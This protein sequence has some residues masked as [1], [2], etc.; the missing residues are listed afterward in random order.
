MPESK[1]PYKVNGAV[2][3]AMAEYIRLEMEL[4]RFE[5][6]AAVRR[7]E[8]FK[9][10]EAGRGRGEVEH[11]SSINVDGQEYVFVYPH[12]PHPTLHYESAVRVEEGGEGE[13]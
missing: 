13:K 1:A 12:G 8:L 7:T 10:I 6:R 3:A 5:K 9:I 2:G 11:Y 4:E